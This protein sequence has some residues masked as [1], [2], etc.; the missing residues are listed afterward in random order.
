MEKGKSERR[1]KA[2]ILWCI[3]LYSAVWISV[4]KHVHINA[5][6]AMGE[7]LCSACPCSSLWM[8]NL[9]LTTL[10]SRMLNFFFLKT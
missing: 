4:G 7:K 2:L 6:T 10:L 5:S 8:S 1:R 9:L 3:L